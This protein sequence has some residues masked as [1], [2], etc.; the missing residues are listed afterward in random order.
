MLG[1]PLLGGQIQQVQLRPQRGKLRIPVN[2]SASSL[3]R[4]RSDDGIGYGQVML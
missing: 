1:Q 2:E 3:K 4:R